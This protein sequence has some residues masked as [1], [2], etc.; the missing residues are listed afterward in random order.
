M[1]EMSPCKMLD[2]QAHALCV[3]WMF[4]CVRGGSYI[5]HLD[6]MYQ[7]LLSAGRTAAGDMDAPLAAGSNMPRA[8]SLLW[9]IACLLHL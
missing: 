7:L 1:T 2:D 6:L 4:P 9:L 5:S 3:W 8:I